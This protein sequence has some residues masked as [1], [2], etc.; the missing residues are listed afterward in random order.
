MNQHPHADNLQEIYY[1][2]SEWIRMCNNIIWNM[3][4]FL[5]PLSIGCIP[6]VIQY[7]KH[8]FFLAPASIFI[9][10]FWIYVSKLYRASAVST[11]HVLMEIEREWGVKQEMALYNSHGQVG[12]SRLG[13][14]STQIICLV[15]LAVIWILLLTVVPLEAWAVR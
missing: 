2:A 4:T 10:A 3:G 12:L 15:V 9:F 7:P 14:F 5:M 1:Q 13:L 6:I 11:R 8:R